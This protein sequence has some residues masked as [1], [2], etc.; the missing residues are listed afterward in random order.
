MSKLLPILGAIMLYFVASQ[1][2]NLF[3]LG[4]P[5]RV[6]IGCLGAAMIIGSEVARRIGK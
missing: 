2:L 1:S 6:S 3:D 5:A 4:K